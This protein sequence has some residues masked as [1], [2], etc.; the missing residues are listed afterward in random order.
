[1]KIFHRVA[2]IGSL[3]AL[4]SAPTLAEDNPLP[5]S[6]TYFI[7]NASSGQALQPVEPSPGQNVYVYEYKQSGAQKWTIT[8]HVDPKTKK[9]TNRYNI[10]LA[11]DNQGLNFQ[12]HPSISDAAAIVGGD[13]SV[14]TLQSNADG[15]VV[16]SVTKNGDALTIYQSPP[17]DTET[18]FGPSDGSDKFRW[19]FISAN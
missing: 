9:P 11:G 5:D 12:P 8:R 4:A 16:K 10:R 19:N 13:K 3:I 18:R 15:Y 17:S 7:V 14:F 6:G 2:V 1:M